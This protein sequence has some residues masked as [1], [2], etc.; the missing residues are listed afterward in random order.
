MLP[1]KNFNS[2]FFQGNSNFLQ[3]VILLNKCEKLNPQYCKW[4]L[5]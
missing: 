2:D 1:N 5:L 4:S 3:K